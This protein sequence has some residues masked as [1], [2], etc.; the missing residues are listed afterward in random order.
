MYPNHSKAIGLAYGRINC[1]FK[2]PEAT[3]MEATTI[4]SILQQSWGVS[5]DKSVSLILRAKKKL[6]N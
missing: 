3:G 4:N 2:Y 5:I 1:Y 6:C